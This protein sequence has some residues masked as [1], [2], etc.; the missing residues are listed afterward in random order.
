MTLKIKLHFWFFL[1]LVLMPT[2]AEFLVNKSKE[3][4]ERTIKYLM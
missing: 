3:E 2:V 1:N 4:R